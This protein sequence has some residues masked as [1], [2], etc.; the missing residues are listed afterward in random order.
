[1]VSLSAEYRDC[2]RNINKLLDLQ[3]HT[4]VLEPKYSK[5]VAE[6]TSLR[7]FDIITESFAS[8]AKKI[9]SGATYVDGTHPLILCRARSTAAAFDSMCTKGR[10]KPKRMLNWAKVADIKDNTKYVIDPSDHFIKTIDQHSLFINEM[11]VVRNRIAHNNDTSRKHYRKVVLRYYGA[12]LNSV[13]PGVL[14]LSPRQTPSIVEQYLHKSK[15][16]MKALVKA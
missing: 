5:I 12:E 9:V 14:L 1:M 4:A 6:I 13:S 15:A 8:T 7:L 3:T 16:L 11:R 10:P 2:Y